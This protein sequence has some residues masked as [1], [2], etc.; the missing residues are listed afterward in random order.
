MGAYSEPESLGNARSHVLSEEGPVSAAC[1][2]F[3]LSSR[4]DERSVCAGNR[5]AGTPEAVGGAPPG[6]H[7]PA[8]RL[9]PRP[10][11]HGP[12]HRFAVITSL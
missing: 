1:T 5:E 8:L 2:R 12:A 10:A 4:R 9:P 7:A 3:R 6:G 11:P